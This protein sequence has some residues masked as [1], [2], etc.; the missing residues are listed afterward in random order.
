MHRLEASAGEK[1]EDSGHDEGQS[2]RQ[3]DLLH[4]LYRLFY[5]EKPEEEEGQ[6]EGGP[7]LVAESSLVEEMPEQMKTQVGHDEQVKKAEHEP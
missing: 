3:R 7:G 2:G 6:D 4:S 5:Q 1:A